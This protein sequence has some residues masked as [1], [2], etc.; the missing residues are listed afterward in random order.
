MRGCTGRVAVA[1]PGPGTA[2][3]TVTDPGMVSVSDADTGTDPV[4]VTDTG[5][6]PAE[7]PV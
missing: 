6:S 3:D 2:T 7:A 1:D 4:A 5:R